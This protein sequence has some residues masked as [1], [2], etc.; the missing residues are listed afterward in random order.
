MLNS[1]DHS[2]W[3]FE[4][5]RE[6]FAD[7]TR[8]RRA[9]QEVLGQTDLDRDEALLRYLKIY[10]Y[11]HLGQRTPAQLLQDIQNAGYYEV[12]DSAKLDF[13]FG[14]LAKK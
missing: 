13:A 6:F 14:Q 10:G 11:A 9:Y 5:Q 3:D 7:C 4:R 1:E 8:F 2:P 12:I